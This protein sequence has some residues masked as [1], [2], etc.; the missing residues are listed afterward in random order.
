MDRGEFL[1]RSSTSRLLEILN[2]CE[3]GAQRIRKL[4]P[5]GA[6]YA[7]KTGTLGLGLVADVGILQPKGTKRRVAVAVYALSRDGSDRDRNR[8][9][10]KVGRALH[11]HF[12]A[13]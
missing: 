4:L 7:S 8:A 13:T 2:R 12:V 6:K 3:T 1:R 5:R 10:Q 11:D 9:I